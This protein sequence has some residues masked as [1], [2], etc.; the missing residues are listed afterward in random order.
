MARLGMVSMDVDM[1][2][3]ICK[4]QCLQQSHDGGDG[5]GKPAGLRRAM[6][7]QARRNRS[8]VQC[9]VKHRQHDDPQAAAL[10]VVHVDHW[11]HLDSRLST[12]IPASTTATEHAHT[13]AP[14][15]CP[16]L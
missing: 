1:H 15:Q 3:D 11:Q 4:Q 6:R 12:R 9:S 8:A 13:L 10:L 7:T 2:T 16:S 14:K 5:E